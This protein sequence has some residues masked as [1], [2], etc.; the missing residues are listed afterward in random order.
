MYAKLDYKF[1]NIFGFIFKIYYFFRTFVKYF[2]ILADPQS[3]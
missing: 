3:F 1:I 2:I